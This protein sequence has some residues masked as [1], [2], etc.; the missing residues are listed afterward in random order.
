MVL[1]GKYKVAAREI[2]ANFTDQCVNNKYIENNIIC[3]MYSSTGTEEII[4]ICSVNLLSTVYG[5][6]LA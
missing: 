4:F 5:S 2:F 1:C 3:E 6:I